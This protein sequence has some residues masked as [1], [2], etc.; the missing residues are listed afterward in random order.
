MN[1]IFVRLSCMTLVNF[2]LNK[3]GVSVSHGLNLYMKF[4]WIRTRIKEIL[5]ILQN[6]TVLIYDT[7]RLFAVQVLFFVVTTCNSL[8]CFCNS[9]IYMCCVSY[10]IIF[11]HWNHWGGGHKHAADAEWQTIQPFNS[12]ADLHLP[13]KTFLPHFKTN[14]CSVVSSTCFIFNN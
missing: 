1:C 12:T 6:I 4:V 8:V 3:C 13:V 10:I 11:I 5:Q 14:W 7:M 9:L 2:L